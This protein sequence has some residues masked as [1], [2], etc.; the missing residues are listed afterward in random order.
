MIKTILT[1]NLTNDPVLREV[2]YTDKNTGEIRKFKVCNFSVAANNRYGEN[3]T[4]VYF[5]VSVWRGLA[6]SCA[7]YLKKGRGV[8]VEGPISMDNYIDSKGNVRTG[9]KIDAVTV[10]FLGKGKDGEIAVDNAEQPE[11]EEGLY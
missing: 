8:M 6:E 3:R 11:A 10:E 1:G 2:E 7:T 5:N 4:T 9:L